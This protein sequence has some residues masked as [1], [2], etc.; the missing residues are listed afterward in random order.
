MLKKSGFLCAAVLLSAAPALAFSGVSAKFD[1]KYSGLDEVV[2]K[3]SSPSCASHVIEDI[4]IKDGKL[5]SSA[6]NV[7]VNGFITEEGYLDASMKLASGNSAELD[8]RLVEGATISA[9]AIDNVAGCS[10]IVKLQKSE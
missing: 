1:G 7:S 10:W 2:E 8:G 9:G 4:A 3:T 5:R 6:S